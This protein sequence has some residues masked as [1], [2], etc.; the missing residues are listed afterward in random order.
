MASKKPTTPKNPNRNN[1]NSGNRGNRG[2]RGNKPN[3]QQEKQ[4]IKQELRQKIE[5]ELYKLN[6]DVIINRMSTRD[7]LFGD[8]QDLEQLAKS[9]EKHEKRNTEQKCKSKKSDKNTPKID[10]KLK[11]IEREK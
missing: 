10:I 7:E 2:N 11:L 3:P 5:E 6:Q 9:M 4:E 8:N 1:S